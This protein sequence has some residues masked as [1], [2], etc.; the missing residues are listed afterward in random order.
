MKTSRL[1]NHL[2]DPR[3]SKPRNGGQ[4]I[5]MR[6][7]LQ[8]IGSQYNI[9][10]GTREDHQAKAWEDIVLRGKLVTFHYSTF[11]RM[12]LL[13]LQGG[14]QKLQSP[15]TPINKKPE[16]DNRLVSMWLN[17][18]QECIIRYRENFYR[19][20]LWGWA[21]CIGHWNG[22]NNAF[23]IIIQTFAIWIKYTIIDQTVW[24]M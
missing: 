24:V 15:N 17:N 14:Q 22:I 7:C 11:P 5:L 6:R 9:D 21:K 10:W 2:T 4:N 20:A 16:P 19:N 12:S 1:F 3:R 23:F 13:N 18:K 8:G